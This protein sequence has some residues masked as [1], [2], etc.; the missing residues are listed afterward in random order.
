MKKRSKKQPARNLTNEGQRPADGKNHQRPACSKTQVGG[1]Q[2]RL[3]MRCVALDL[4]ASKI[5]FCELSV[6]GTVKK[7][8]A[9]TSLNGLEK[10]LGPNTVKARVAFE[11]CR[12]A[13]HVASK[14]TE[15]GHE[16]VLVDTTRAT[17]LG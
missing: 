3:A 12:E 2:G 13:W 14:L 1:A 17:Q 8:G 15:W 11:A 16:P 5:D 4:S 9:T 6:D 10:L 7:K